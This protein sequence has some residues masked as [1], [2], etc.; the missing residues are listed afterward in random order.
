[1]AELSKEYAAAL[2]ALAGEQNCEEEFFS[3][4]QL[5]QKEFDAAPEYAQI[6]SAPNVPA[7][8]R[9]ALLDQ[10]FAET[11]P[12]Y[13][14]SLVKLMCE[15]GHI[16]LLGDCAK[17]YEFLYQAFSRTSSARVVSAVEL[18]EDEKKV[19]QAKLETISKRKVTAQYEIDSA[20]MGGLV[21]Y[22]DD[23]VIDG[24]LRTKLKELKEVIAT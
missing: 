20:L 11:V 3:A 10:A 22:M 9:C 8:E 2:F 1:M 18:T 24:S 12:E 13:V 5:L 15:K 4:L 14:L 21:I 17:E 6:L 23:T 19:L 7:K 16:R